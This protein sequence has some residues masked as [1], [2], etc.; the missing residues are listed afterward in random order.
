ML[1]IVTCSATEGVRNKDIVRPSGT[2][3]AS[4]CGLG[5][6]NLQV[7]CI[8]VLA[9]GIF[10]GHLVVVDSGSNRPMLVSVPTG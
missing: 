10:S 4:G 2:V 5:V 1:L 7:L 6:D 3:I 9:V 8:N